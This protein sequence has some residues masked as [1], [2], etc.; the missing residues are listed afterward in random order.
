MPGQERTFAL[1][2][3]PPLVGGLPQSLLLLAVVALGPALW[4]GWAAVLAL[5]ALLFL[6]RV[7]F[8]FERD[9]PHILRNAARHATRGRLS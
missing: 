9:F 2:S 3:K 1:L 4:L 8:D 7:L 5:A 6:L